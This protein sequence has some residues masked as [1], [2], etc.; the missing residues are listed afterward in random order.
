MGRD[1]CVEEATL[2]RRRLRLV[3]AKRAICYPDPDSQYCSKLIDS[4]KK[5]SVMEFVDY[6]NAL[7][8]G[9]RILGRGWSSNVFLAVTLDG[10]IVA[11]KALRPDS[12]RKSLLWEGSVWSVASM[13]GVAPRLQAAD[14]YFVVYTPV[15]GPVIGEYMPKNSLEW[16]YVLRLIIDKTYVLDVLGIA[17]N[18]L[19]R[20]EQ[21]ILLDSCSKGLPEPFIID[22]ESSTLSAKPRNVSQVIGGLHRVKAFTGC[23][24]DNYLRNMLREYRSTLS[25]RLLAEIREYV[26]MKCV[27]L[28]TRN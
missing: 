15:L 21:H 12:R 25:P 10:S 5:A 1:L 6:G 18:E 22:Y 2:A 17:H 23:M 24:V 27:R 16:E 4:L 3:E 8:A 13:A 20:P 7:V 14:R 28:S 11:V 19:A 9:L 26:V